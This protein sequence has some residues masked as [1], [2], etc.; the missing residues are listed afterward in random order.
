MKKDIIN[1]YSELINDMSIA[2]D[3]IVNDLR[4]HINLLEK[5]VLELEGRD[6]EAELKKLESPMPDDLVEENKKLKKELQSLRIKVGQMKSKT[7]KKA[8]PKKPAKKKSGTYLVTCQVCGKDFVSK[9]KNAKYCKSCKKAKA[10]EYAN[11]YYH[12][13]KAESSKK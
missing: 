10:A 6:V 13:T 3:S 4:F 12:K 9:S 11:K 2:H 1:K 7:E 8:E 5:R